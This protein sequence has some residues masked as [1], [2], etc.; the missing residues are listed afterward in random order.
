MHM[1]MWQSTTNHKQHQTTTFRKLLQSVRI[2]TPTSQLWIWPFN[3]PFPLSLADLDILCLQS[4]HSDHHLILSDF[5]RWAPVPVNAVFSVKAGRHV[6]TIF[7]FWQI[8]FKSKEI[9]Y[10]YMT[11]MTCFKQKSVPICEYV[12][13]QSYPDHRILICN[14][15]PKTCRGWNKFL[16][17]TSPLGGR[18]KHHAINPFCFLLWLK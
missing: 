8:H 18:R 17:S 2:K 14:I 5:G 7:R 13:I 4:A 10:I 15:F 6:C 9:R 3:E 12:L 16:Q 1:S 11:Y